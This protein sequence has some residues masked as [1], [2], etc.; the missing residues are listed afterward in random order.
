MSHVESKVRH[1]VNHLAAKL[2]TATLTYGYV[3]QLQMG[4]LH[5][6]WNG[7]VGSNVTTCTCG[8]IALK[9]ANF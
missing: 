7:S 9:S 4:R 3:L 2:I 1:G 8:R 5:H 6:I